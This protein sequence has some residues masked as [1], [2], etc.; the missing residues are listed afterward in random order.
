[1]IKTVR[2]YESFLSKEI[3]AF[4]KSARVAAEKGLLR[5][6]I[7]S[8]AVVD[9][10]RVARAVLRTTLAPELTQGGDVLISYIA[11]RGV[12]DRLKRDLGR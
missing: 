3:E 7:H 5:W 1:M 12:P 9:T 4:E 11:Q 8:Q 6:A 2:D 10:Y